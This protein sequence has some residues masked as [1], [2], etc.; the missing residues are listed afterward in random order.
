MR[1]G[2]MEFEPRR[3]FPDENYLPPLDGGLGKPPLFSDQQSRC[4]PF[5]M[6]HGMDGGLVC[7]ALSRRATAMIRK[8]G[9]AF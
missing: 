7:H 6:G 3:N 4:A 1:G 2:I 9:S 5:R 8:P